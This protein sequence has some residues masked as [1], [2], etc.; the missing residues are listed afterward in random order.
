MEKTGN[1]PL[2]VFLA[3]SSIPSRKSAIWLITASVIFTVYCVPWVQ[4]FPAINWVAEWFL[5]KDWSWA[6]MMVP[7]TAWYVLSLRWVDKHDAWA[8]PVPTQI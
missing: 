7:I 1:I 3:F 6:A 8:K 2:W 4:V 5:I